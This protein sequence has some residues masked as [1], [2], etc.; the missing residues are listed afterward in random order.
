MFHKVKKNVAAMSVH[1]IEH[2]ELAD[3]RQRLD[4]ASKALKAGL[5]DIIATERNWTALVGTNFVNFS[6]RFASYYPDDD[7]M[8]DAAKDT[9][10]TSLTLLKTFTT[11]VES[12]TSQHKLMEALVRGYLTEIAAVEKQIRTT[13][14][15]AKVELD[16]YGKKL[17]VLQAK[18]GTARDEGKIGR[19]LEKFE[20]ARAAY[21]AAVVVAADRCKGIWDKRRV[22][23][24]ALFV[25]YFQAQATAM[26]SCLSTLQSTFAFVDSN[27][28]VFSQLDPEL[29]DWAG[30]EPQ[31][32]QG[33]LLSTDEAAAAVRELLPGGGDG[34]TPVFP[35]RDGFS[36]SAT[37]PLCGAPAALAGPPCS[38]SIPA[39]A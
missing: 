21:D 30:V 14:H 9:A 4:G 29:S 26:T 15:G 13:V 3:Y 7:P 22:A 1:T 38:A 31:A 25:G 37:R 19:N 28:E 16:M 34:A 27:R 17:G 36:R 32:A 35:T 39:T 8:R 33:A 20:A 10:S 18:T 5:E 12:T 6:D 2:A 23:F 11:R 24:T